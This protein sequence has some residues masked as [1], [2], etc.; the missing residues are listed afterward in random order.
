MANIPGSNCSS[1]VC[2][3]GYI[4]NVGLSLPAFTR[5]YYKSKNFECVC[6]CVRACV[7]VCMCTCMCIYKEVYKTLCLSVHIFLCV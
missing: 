3:R 5:V 6:V 2:P 1:S 4:F 7:C